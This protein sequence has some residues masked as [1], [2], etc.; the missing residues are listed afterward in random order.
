MQLRAHLSA[1][2]LSAGGVYWISG[3]VGLPSSRTAVDAT[4]RCKKRRWT[5][6]VASWRLGD[7]PYTSRRKV[8]LK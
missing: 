4:S 5:R 8:V 6:A 1:A 2:V 7:N 3:R